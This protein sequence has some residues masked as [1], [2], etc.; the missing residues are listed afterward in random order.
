[1]TQIPLTQKILASLGEALEHAMK[2]EVLDGYPRNLCK[3]ISTKDNNILQ[4]RAHISTL[5]EKIQDLALP[6][7]SRPLVRC[8]GCYTKGHMVTKCPKS[9]GGGV[10]SHPMSP[11]LV[12]PSSSVA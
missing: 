9:W 10:V 7:G 3:I 4:L 12:G 8:T 6:G 5:T 1:L 2:I 11:P